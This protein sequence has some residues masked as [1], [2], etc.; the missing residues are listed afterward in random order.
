MTTCYEPI[1]HSQAQDS[2]WISQIMCNFGFC[3]GDKFARTTAFNAS[4]RVAA[5]TNWAVTSFIGY[6]PSPAPTTFTD[7]F[8]AYATSTAPTPSSSSGTTAGR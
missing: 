8:F 5:K 3:S 1:R 2:L 7:G 6:N 4:R